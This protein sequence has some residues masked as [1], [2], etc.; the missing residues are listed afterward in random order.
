MQ[1]VQSGSYQRAEDSTL[2]PNILCTISGRFEFRRRH[3][4]RGPRRIWL[5]I[6]KGK[7]IVRKE[8][9]PNNPQLKL[10]FEW[11]SMF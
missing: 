3:I 10:G 4:Q 5:D 6:A 9:S 2:I 11:L 1:T 8:D 7:E